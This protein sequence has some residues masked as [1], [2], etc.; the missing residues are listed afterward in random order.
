MMN[1]SINWKIIPLGDIAEFHNGINFDKSSFG[2]G[3]KIIGVSDFQD[4][5]YP[6]YSSLDEVNPKGIVHKEHLLEENDILFVRSNGNRQLIGRSLFLKNLREPLTH[7]AF[8]IRARFTSKATS[9][10]FYFYLFRSSLIRD[11]LS[12]QGSGTNISNLNQ[13][14]LSKLPVPFPTL[15]TQQKIAAILSAYD[16]LIENN[17]RR[18]KILEEMAQ[19]MYREWFV[20]FRFPGHEGVRIVESE[21]GPVPEGWEVQTVEKT[22]EILGGGTPSTKVQE[23]WKSGEINWYSPVDLTAAGTMF[24][25]NSGNKINELG[26][27]KSSARLFPAF[28]V[29]MTS[30]ATLGV[31]SINTTEACT[32]QGFITCIPNAKFPLYLLYHWLKEN[33]GYLISLGTGST[34]KEITKGTFK[35][36]QLVVPQ[37]NVAI[38]FEK[39]VE[40]LAAQILCLQRKNANLRRTRDLLLPK[41]ISGKIDVSDLNIEIPVPE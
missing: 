2:S 4:F 9:P 7:S 17:T 12:N 21:L 1:Y 8:T 34:F 5:L 27:K 36:V 6:N 38:Q 20:N 13:D 23:Y 31:I 24:I 35:T 3:I 15:V 28:S 29:M 22:F 39:I 11:V 25:E 18:I 26:L 40:P 32:N 37:P 41:L 19:A 14:I 10:K 33:V 30:R 16:D